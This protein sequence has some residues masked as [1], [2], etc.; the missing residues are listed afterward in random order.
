MPTFAGTWLWIPR[1]CTPATT[2]SSTGTARSGAFKEEEEEE[3]EEEEW[4]EFINLTTDFFP[5][6]P[7]GQGDVLACSTFF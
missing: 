6:L 7:R 5:S 2:T 4:E 3:E 1:T